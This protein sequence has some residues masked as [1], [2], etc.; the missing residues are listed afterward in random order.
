MKKDILCRAGRI[1]AVIFDLDGTLLNTLE[2]I[3]NAVNRVLLKRGYST[4]PID[5]YRQFVGDGSEMLIKRAIP[6]S[7]STPDRV[8]ACLDEFKTEYG[9]TWDVTTKPYAGIP[10]LLNRLTLYGVRL[11]VLSNKP[12]VFARQ[13]VDRQLA[14]WTFE[15]VIGFSSRFPK[16]PDPAGALSIVEDLGLDKGDCLFMGDSGVDMQTAA[17]AGLFPVGAAW[18]FRSE[19]ELMEYGCRFLARHPMD[20]LSLL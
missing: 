1:K 12:H 16:K 14:A 3:G 18:G 7:N 11:A 8:L 10:E 19:A 15:K 6:E 2:D 9:K 17:A 5:S 4:H 13:C 20:V